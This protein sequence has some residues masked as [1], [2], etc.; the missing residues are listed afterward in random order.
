MKRTN[1]TYGQLDRVLRALGFTFRRAQQE[2]R[3]RLYEH[4]ETGARIA[5]AYFPDG[6]K[7][8]DYHLAA[9][10]ATLDNYGIADPTTFAAELQKAG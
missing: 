9:A 3:A 1:V 2:P 4:E 6:E 5:L 10:R 7:V 8:V